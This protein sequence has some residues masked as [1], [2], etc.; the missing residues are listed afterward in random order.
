MTHGIDPIGD[1]LE[2]RLEAYAGARLSPDPDA[3]ARTRARVVREADFVFAAKRDAAAV[4][5]ADRA[6]GRLAWRARRVRAALLA[7]ALTLSVA[8]ASVAFA[9]DA[10]DPLYGLRVWWETA[11]LPQAGD[12]RAAAEI[13][14][15]DTRMMELA[16]AVEAGDGPAA[17]AAAA[18]F[19]A[20]VDEAVL[21]ATGDARRETALEA[22]LS[23]HVVVLTGLLDKVP[24]NA[25]GAI[26][27]AIGQ[28]GNAIDSIGGEPTKVPEPAATDRPGKTPKPANSNRPSDP[29]PPP[30]GP[31][32]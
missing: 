16:M 22:A 7:A 5:A 17:E 12:A 31:G 1:E 6:S 25:R 20:I 32:G 15:L 30:G 19:R 24:E 29:G 14:R 8:M 23:R 21:G 18:A 3:T 26:Q 28:S 4:V 10:G 9:S 2:Q 27:H 11:V 13:E